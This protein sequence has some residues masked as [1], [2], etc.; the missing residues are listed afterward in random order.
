VSAEDADGWEHRWRHVDVP[1]LEA[2]EAHFIYA[3]DWV[4]FVDEELALRVGRLRDHP[5]PKPTERE[6]PPAHNPPAQRIPP[7]L[8][9]DQKALHL[10][11][12]QAA[13]GGAPTPTPGH[14]AMEAERERKR[15]ERAAQK[16]R[17]LKGHSVPEP[18]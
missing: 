11:R 2:Q 9:E 8:N 1:L 15:G 6:P 5:W 12:A 13:R 14:L 7:W 4:Y 10:A 16:E 3:Q 18:E 17:S